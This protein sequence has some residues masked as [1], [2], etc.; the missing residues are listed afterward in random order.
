MTCTYRSVRGARV[1]RHRQ[2]LPEALDRAVH[3][4]RGRE[5]R[6]ERADAEVDR[7]PPAARRSRATTARIASGI[8]PS[9]NVTRDSV[10]RLVHLGVAQRVGLPREVVERVLRPAE[11]LEDA[12]AVHGLLDGGREVARLVARPPR[13]DLVVLAEPEARARSSGPRPRRRPAP[14]C[15]LVAII[16][17]TPTTTVVALTHSM[18]SP[19]TSQRRIEP[20][21]PIDRDSSWPPDHRSWN[22]TGRSSRWRNIA[23]R[24]SRSTF[25]PGVA[26]RARRHQTRNASRTPSTST[27]RGGPDHR[28]RASRR[29]AA[30]R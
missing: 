23:T 25:V 18:T 22:S 28:P 29:S 24:M 20:R 14:S 10:L 13:D 17:P 7:A 6:D 4:R 19:N 21:S 8:A 11:R 15:Q 16:R 26:I 9:A 5:E 2:E 3:D 27:T 12:D 1:E 30:A